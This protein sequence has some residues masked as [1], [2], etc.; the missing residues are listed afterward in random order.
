MKKRITN[1]VLFLL[2]IIYLATLACCTDDGRINSHID[3]E[4]AEA[5]S[6]V[7]QPLFLVV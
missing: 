3:N 1:I 2:I 6:S 4:K 5:E 7:T